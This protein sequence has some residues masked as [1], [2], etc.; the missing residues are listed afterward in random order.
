M[1]NSQGNLAQIGLS[2]WIKD[3][4]F[5][6]HLR[7]MRRIYQERYFLMI[8]ALDDADDVTSVFAAA[9]DARHCSLQYRDSDALAFVRRREQKAHQS[10][11][12]DS[13]KEEVS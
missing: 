6:R 2:A 13:H 5:E 3:G 10:R 4:G 11:S 1:D 7:R 9:S 8:D 12:C